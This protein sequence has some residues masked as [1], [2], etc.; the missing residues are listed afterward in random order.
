MT[1]LN[2]LMTI[3]DQVAET[4]RVHG[5]ARAQTIAAETLARVGLPY[6]TR[7]PEHFFGHRQAAFAGASELPAVTQRGKVIYCHSPLFGA[8]RKHAV[9]AYRQLV[10]RLLE[11]LVPEALVRAPGLPTTAEVALLRQPEQGRTLLHL[12]HAVPQ[13]RGP[14]IDV[15][16]DVLPL[17]DARVGVRLARPATA[18]TLSPGGERLAHEV[19]DGLTWVTVPRVEGH[20]VVVFE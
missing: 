1:A 4:A 5:R 10:E 3:G 2:P 17:V 12:I 7:T 11:R 9:P 8:Y 19:S 16:E 20:R 13:R 14:E 6:F 15:V 18:V